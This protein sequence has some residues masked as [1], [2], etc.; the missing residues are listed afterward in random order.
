MKIADLYRMF[1]TTGFNGESIS[2]QELNSLLLV[3]QEMVLLMEYRKDAT[4]AASFRVTGESI[5]RM[6]EARNQ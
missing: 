6:I 4:M 3:N 1:D 2:N 5:R